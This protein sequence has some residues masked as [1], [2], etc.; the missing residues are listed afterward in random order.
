MYGTIAKIK[1][2]PGAL[3]VLKKMEQQ[4]QPKG[5]IASYI[6]QM[7]SDPNELWMVVMFESKATYLANAESPEQDTEFRQVRQF[8]EEDPEWH[9]GEIVFKVTQE[10]HPSLFPTP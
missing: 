10:A 3:E 1:G 5:A 4:R 7:D 9:D 2:K 6:Y 8:M